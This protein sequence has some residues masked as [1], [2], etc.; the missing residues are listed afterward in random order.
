[1]YIELAENEDFSQ[2]FPSWI[3]AYFSQQTKDFSFGKMIMSLSLRM[4]L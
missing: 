4:M 1:M 2:V 3:I